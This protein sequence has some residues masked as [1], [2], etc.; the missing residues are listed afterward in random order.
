MTNTWKGHIRHGDSETLFTFN[1][2][3]REKEIKIVSHAPI[4][5]PPTYHRRLP[6]PTCSILLTLKTCH[7]QDYYFTY[8]HTGSWFLIYSMEYIASHRYV[9]GTWNNLYGKNMWNAFWSAYLAKMESAMCC[10]WMLMNALENRMIK[11]AT[12]QICTLFGWIFL[13]KNQFFRGLSILIRKT[14]H[15]RFIYMYESC[16]HVSFD[17]HLIWHVFVRVL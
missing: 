10:L 1:E 5:W 11:L 6:P 15:R 16:F 17:S 2:E 3:S 7:Y 4:C 12:L 13:M 14:N 9:D 8:S